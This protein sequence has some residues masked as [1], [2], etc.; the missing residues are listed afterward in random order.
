MAE[1]NPVDPEVSNLLYGIARRP[2]DAA[3]IGRLASRVQ[4]W[5]AVIELAEGH[6]VSPMVYLSLATA[7]WPSPPAVLQRLR[8]N[9]ERNAAQNLSNAA[10]L[11]AILQEF[12][13]KEIPAIPFKGVVLAAAAY[14]NLLARHSGDLDILIRW[15]DLAKASKLLRDRGYELMTPI[16]ADGQPTAPHVYEYRFCRQATDGIVV[17]LR[18]QFDSAEARRF[19]DSVGLDRVWARR[20][21]VMLAGVEVPHLSPE[22]ALLILCDH[23]IKHTWSLMVWICDIGRILTT[24]PDLDWEATI[25]EARQSGLGRTLAIGV[26]LAHQMVD[27]PVPAPILQRFQST[28]TARRFANHFE[29]VLFVAPGTLPASLIPARLQ[30]LDLRDRIRLCLSPDFLRPNELDRAAIHLPKW[31]SPLY[32]VVRPLRLLLD[33]TPR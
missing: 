17:E 16:R 1:L 32:Y 25:D 21:T 9:Y 22:D 30:F 28:P 18:W 26:L 20:R 27:A 29:K 4:D 8:S 23:G 10:E 14:G 6:R 3:G 24:F 31:L 12:H 15:D 19:R 11:V 5:D 7:E 2:K 13:C 33:R